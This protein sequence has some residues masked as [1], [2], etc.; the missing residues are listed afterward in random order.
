[1]KKEQFSDLLNG[2]DDQLI[3]EAGSLLG[4]RPYFPF[5]MAMLAVTGALIVFFPRLATPTPVNPPSEENSDIL[6]PMIPFVDPSSHSMG[7]E[8]Y[9]EADIIAK[10]NPWTG[11][12]D[13]YPVFKNLAYADPNAASWG[14]GKDEQKQLIQ[15]Y[16][17]AHGLA[18]VSIQ[19][20]GK[21]DLFL[22]AT[23]DQGTI[24]STYYGCLTYSPSNE[25]I[26][27]SDIRL[28]KEEQ[29]KLLLEAYA[30]WQSWFDITHPAFVTTM[31]QGSD[32]ILQ[33]FFYEKSGDELQDILHYNFNRASI[34]F[35]KTDTLVVAQ[36]SMDMRDKVLEE[37]ATYPIR[38]PKEAREALFAGN[39]LSNYPAWLEISNDATIAKCEIVYNTDIHSPIC[40][41]FYKFYIKDTENRKLD[42][43]ME[44]V[45]G[46]Y[47]VPAIQDKYLDDSWQY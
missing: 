16:A 41:P 26:P 18:I 36:L 19:E 21:P 35:R 38:T 32:N 45:Y 7:Y 14:L 23:T 29:E 3:E 43:I 22:T 42:T 33:N 5:A 10:G 9:F 46:A 11:T 13:A 6:L 47:Y 15:A 12:M 31:G 39:Y 40:M 34:I 24:S 17:D 28:N 1:M 8:S 4:K 44:P 20:T 30:T 37:I 2:L 27:P 25:Y